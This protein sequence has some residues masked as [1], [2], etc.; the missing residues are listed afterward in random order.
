MQD[1]ER[2]EEQL[3]ELRRS[4]GLKAEVSEQ[5]RQIAA[6]R[7]QQA[8]LEIVKFQALQA[9]LMVGRRA[10][11]EQIDMMK[12]AEEPSAVQIQGHEGAL[13]QLD[14]IISQ[15]D[16]A[17]AT[18]QGAFNALSAMEE[19]LKQKAMEATARTRG[20]EV[21]Q[22]RSVDLAS[23]ANGEGAQADSAKEPMATPQ[24]RENAS[25]SSHGDILASSAG[26]LGSP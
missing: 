20:L 7:K 13:V 6:D 19:T 25:P 11:V 12:K 21:Q 5:H 16:K 3:E 14:S 2:I 1:P 18:N 9:S 15:A 26:A 17:V 10:L 4:A 23:R 8:E 22:E 24:Q